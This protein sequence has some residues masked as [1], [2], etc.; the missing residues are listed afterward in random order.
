MDPS[1]LYH[2]VE[3]NTVWI[4]LLIPIAVLW[5]APSK[6]VR[7]KRTL[8][9]FLIILTWAFVLLIAK[10]WVSSKVVEQ[11][12]TEWMILKKMK[13]DHASQLEQKAK[14]K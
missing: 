14:A 2:W 9:S 11:R 5:P 7:A 3:Q 13:A 1:I 12:R 10:I 8:I 6:K 4:V